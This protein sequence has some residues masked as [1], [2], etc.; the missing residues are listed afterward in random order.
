[1]RKNCLMF[2]L[3]A[4]VAAL[5][6]A[7]QAADDPCFEKAQTQ[8]QLN[9]CATDGLKR[10]DNELNSLFKQMTDRLGNDKKARQLLVDAQRKWI[11]FRDAECSFQVMR[12]AGGSIQP[13]RQRMCHAAITQA[14]VLD[15]H[16]QL[17]CGKDADE[18]T[19]AECAVPPANK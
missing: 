10:A 6:C 5:P 14:R 7:A 12:S 19:A 9:A 16:K 18:Q 13:M 1:M 11:S 4:L 15:F 8:A 3:A 17:A 2:L